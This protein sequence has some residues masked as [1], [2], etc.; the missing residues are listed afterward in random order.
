MLRLLFRW[1]LD[2][3][4]FIL[5]LPFYLVGRVLG[6]IWRSFQLGLIDGYYWMEIAAMK[7]LQVKNN[8]KNEDTSDK[9]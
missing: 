9:E 2:V 6:F 1:L 3:I 5:F 4:L 7:D 8:V